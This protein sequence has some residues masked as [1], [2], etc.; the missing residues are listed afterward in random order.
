M[1]DALVGHYVVIQ[2]LVNV[3]GP[4]LKC[5]L[6]NLIITLSNDL[7]FIGYWTLLIYDISSDFKCT[8]KSEFLYPNE[9]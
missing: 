9:Y 6:L 5:G 1:L 3:A 2:G 7:I 4:H 8:N